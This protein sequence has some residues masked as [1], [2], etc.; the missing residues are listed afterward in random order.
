MGS[1]AAFSS[2]LLFGMATGAGVFVFVVVVAWLG[3]AAITPAAWLKPRP[4]SGSIAR[5]VV[6]VPTGGVGRVAY[7]AGGK[8]CSMAARC[9]EARAI[10]SG[11]E[12]VVVDVSRGT[13]TIAPLH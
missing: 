10:A 3:H 1:F 2:V 13:A 12:V 8:R 7:T 6:A 9:S 4:L 5:V 11:A